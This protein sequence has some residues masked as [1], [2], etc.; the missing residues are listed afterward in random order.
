MYMNKFM[1]VKVNDHLL[2]SS[3]QDV[4]LNT[5]ACHKS[6]N[7]DNF[8][9]PNSMSSTHCLKQNKTVSINNKTTKFSLENIENEAG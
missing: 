9:L 6:V 4:S 3:L 8:L 5:F 2:L 7:V 1:Q